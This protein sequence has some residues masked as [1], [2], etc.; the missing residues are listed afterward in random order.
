M[1]N[2]RLET[3]RRKNEIIE[4][5]T[6]GLTKRKIADWLVERYDICSGEAYRL[7]REALK[8]IQEST[9]DFDISDLRTEYIERINSWIQDAV[10]NKDM[11]TALKCQD[12]LNKINQLYVEKQEVTVTND[13]IKFKFD[14]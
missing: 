5:L 7:I 12:M 6:E 8:D 14:S 4:K 9:K 1:P 3:K 2:P 10:K 11:K 13:V